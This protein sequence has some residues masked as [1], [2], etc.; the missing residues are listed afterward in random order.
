MSD[1]NVLIVPAGSGMAIAAIKALRLD[2]DMRITS[3]DGDKLAPGLYLSHRGYIVP[4][5][6]TEA[7]YSTLKK[8]IKKEKVKVIIPAL[9]T[10]LLDFSKRKRDFESVGAKVLVSNPEAIEIARDKWK[11]YVDLKNIMPL[12]RSFIRKEDIDIDYP[13]NIKPR[14]GS[15]SQQVY[16]VNSKEE[17]EFFFDRVENPIVQEYLRGKEYSV[18][19]L[20]DMNGKLLLCISR[21][22]IETKAGISVKGRITKDKRLEDIAKNFASKLRFTGPFF[23]QAKE[24][25]NGVPKLIEINARIA[26]TMCLSSFSGPNIHSLAVRL[27]I[28]ERVKI[29]EI[30]YGLYVTRYWEEIYLTDEEISEK[31][32]SI[33]E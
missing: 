23:F 8:I 28:G 24:D 6:R 11:T 3:A 32:C 4:P 27:C 30:R 33:N 22:R 1:I 17:L 21:E 29:P 12:P 26:G 7:F 18:D 16:K 19:C 15:G 14:S 10:I 25:G 2:K 13:L 20:S 5:F 9:D 31:I